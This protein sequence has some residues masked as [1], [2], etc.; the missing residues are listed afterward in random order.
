MRAGWF[1]APMRHPSAVKTSGTDRTRREGVNSVHRMVTLALPLPLSDI[2]ETCPIDVATVVLPA[3]LA[4]IR[5]LLTEAKA[6]A[7]TRKTIEARAAT[8][9]DTG[10]QVMTLTNLSG[11]I[12]TVEAPLT[13]AAVAL[14]GAGARN[15]A[16][17]PIETAG[18]PAVVKK[19]TRAATLDGI[20]AK[21]P[22]RAIAVS[23]RGIWEIEG[24]ARR[25]HW[26]GGLEV[27]PSKAP[28][29]ATARGENR[30]CPRA[31]TAMHQRGA[32]AVTGRERGVHNTM[33]WKNG[34]Y[35]FTSRRET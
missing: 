16:L 32:T 20:P 24:T 12:T 14:A 29:P 1:V 23:F 25:Q 33:S 19:D 18:A 4:W 26:G 34:R 9:V 8:V 21:D 2:V 27:V 3:G 10:C 35:W 5:A 22:H 30:S 6:G 15:P 31:G 7:E 11:E 13:D 17:L 28:C